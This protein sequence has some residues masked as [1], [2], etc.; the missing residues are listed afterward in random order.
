VAGYS[1]STNLTSLVPGATG[2]PVHYPASMGSL[3]N[4]N[5]GATEMIKQLMEK[6][7]ACPSQ[8]Y[9]LGG[10]S[11]GGFV[12]VAT[13]SKLPA[14]IL[15][16][17]VAVTIF[18]SSPCPASVQGRCISYCQAGDTVCFPGYLIF[19][20]EEVITDSCH[21]RCVLEVEKEVQK[22]L[23][24]PKAP[25]VLWFSLERLGIL[26][27]LSEQNWQSLHQNVLS[28]LV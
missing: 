15:N 21:D 24:A 6:S 9:A 17:V 10:H 2:W 23:R 8:K 1:L 5:I 19:I 11:Q 26:N 28:T 25:K 22:M 14:D 3:S 7:R 16:K 18:G 27:L 13:I 12:T 4:P 20:N